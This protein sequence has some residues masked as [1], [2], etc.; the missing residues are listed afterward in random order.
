MQVRI[1]IWEGSYCKTK[2]REEERGW[3]SSLHDVDRSFEGTSKK[4]A[5]VVTVV[6]TVAAGSL[7]M[8]P[9]GCSFLRLRAFLLIFT[10]VVSTVST[11]QLWTGL[12]LRFLHQVTG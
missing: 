1:H 8:S 4:V 10:S 6:G 7:P 5:T 9:S 2:T 11:P 3:C 12:L